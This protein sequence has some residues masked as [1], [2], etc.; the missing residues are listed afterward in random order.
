MKKDGKHITRWKTGATKLQGA[1]YLR[2]MAEQGWILEGMNHLMYTFREEEPQ[3]LKYRLLK[4]D[5]VM[6]LEEREAFEK[7]GWTE[8]CH[9][10]LE[11]VFVKERDPFE[12]DAEEEKELV[13]EELDRKIKLERENEKSNNIMQITTIAIVGLTIFLVSGFSSDVIGVTGKM[14]VKLLPWI[15]LGTILSRR[16]LK[17]L[18]QEKEAVMEGDIPDEYTDWRSQRKGLLRSLLLIAVI[19]FIWVYYVG[20]KNEVLYDLPQEINYMRVPAPRLEKLENV[21]LIRVGGDIARQ[22][23]ARGDHSWHIY[24]NSVTEQENLF[25]MEEFR[26]EQNMAPVGEAT[27]IEMSTLYNQFLLEPL[28][29]YFYKEELKGEEKSYP[30]MNVSTKTVLDAPRGN[31]DALHVCKREYVDETVI[32]ILCRDGKQ[33]MKLTYNGKAE[34]DDILVEIQKVFLAQK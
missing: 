34:V 7:D 33:V 25:I 17:K 10:E 13:L 11:Y 9:Y 14:A 4:R 18:H 12:E 5:C 32:H 29:E 26:I 21:E 27:E 15:L 24:D 6:A 1:A 30:G 3:Y 31:F 2:E 20:G 22:K 28:A 23:A 16:R 8:V 19:I